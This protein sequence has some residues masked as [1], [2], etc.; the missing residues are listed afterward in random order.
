M[1]KDV[2]EKRLKEVKKTI[3]EWDTYP[4]GTKIAISA[5]LSMARILTNIKDT[6]KAG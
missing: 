1:V 4:E 2:E 3:E 6:E 5:A